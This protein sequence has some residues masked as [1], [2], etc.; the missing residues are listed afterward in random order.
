MPY[1]SQWKDNYFDL[2]NSTLMR[3][4][5]K[6]WSLLALILYASCILTFLLSHTPNAHLSSKLCNKIREIS[7]SIDEMAYTRTKWKPKSFL[8]LQM[9]YFNIH[10]S[11]IALFSSSSA[12]FLLMFVQIVFFCKLEVFQKFRIHSL[13]F[14]PLFGRGFSGR[15]PMVFSV[16]VMIGMILWLCHCVNSDCYEK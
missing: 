10:Q 5:V 1:A 2:I 13:H 8:H 3:Y 16:L 15:I 9:F 4:G 6:N 14:D 7:T 11:L 12:L